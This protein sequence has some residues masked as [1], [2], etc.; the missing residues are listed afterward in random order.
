[1]QAVRSR[2]WFLFGCFLTVGWLLLAQA[3]GNSFLLFSC[4]AV[5]LALVIWSVIQDV[6]L[7]T[8]LFFLPFASLLKIRPG[9]ISLFTVAL[10][11]VY[12]M[13]F[14]KS[15][16]K[17]NVSYFVPGL[18]LIA[19]SLL[20]K[21]LYGYEI[22]NSFILFSASLLLIPLL[23]RELGEGYDFYALTL[24]FALGIITA[25][26]T[27]QYMISFSN[28]TRYV[29]LHELNGNIRHS[30]YYGDPNF[31][32]AHIS[33]ALGGALILVLNNSQKI[34]SATL[35]LLS[36]SLLYCGFL[37]V[38]KSFMLVSVF[39]LLFWGV[40]FVFKRGMLSAKFMIFLVA[41]MGVFFLLSS[42]VFVGAFDMMLFRFGSGKSLSDL[43]TG[44]TDLW[45]Q[46]LNALRED[47]VL[48]FFGRGFT[49]VLVNNR[50]SHNT[51]LQAVYQFGI[52]GCVCLVSWIIC[53]VRT[54]LA[55]TKIKREHLTQI[56][57]LLIGAVG[58]WMALDL[59][60]FDEF[61]LI[62]MYV[63][64][65]ILFLTQKEEERILDD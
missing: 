46:Y 54:M 1:M 62:P 58:P 36:V 38:S 50:G 9:T 17:I 21:I 20:V 22:D 43:T 11:V 16:R 13:C 64:L 40:E 10:L 56:A 51:I 3:L 14:V 57:I 31:Y 19:L 8:L 61:F 49:K 2:Y 30:G 52:I 59:L 18:L 7:P 15:F 24:F 53:Y 6:A 39:L 4:L 28:I 33:A 32:A 44:R 35:V 5:F 34:R 55:K 26:I 37:S 63:C 41:L 23:E 12:A 47:P 42:T 48:L 65:G 27:S 25:A 45:M 29:G 60:F